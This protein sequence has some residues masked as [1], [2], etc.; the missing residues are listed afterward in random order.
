MSNPY[1]YK[2][3]QNVAVSMITNLV[4][5]L[6]PDIPDLTVEVEFVD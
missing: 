4:K 1:I 2:N 5:E 3:A 6:N